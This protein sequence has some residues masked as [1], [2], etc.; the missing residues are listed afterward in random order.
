LDSH[1]LNATQHNYETK[2]ALKITNC[3]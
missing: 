1:S 2:L 3:A